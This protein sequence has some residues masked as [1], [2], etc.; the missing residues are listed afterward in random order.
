M[1]ASE[2][3]QRPAVGRLNPAADSK[4]VHGQ[5]ATRK[6]NIGE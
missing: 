5:P 3:E 6:A 4:K 1:G 2:A